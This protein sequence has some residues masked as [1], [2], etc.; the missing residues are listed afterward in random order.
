MGVMSGTLAAVDGVSS[1]QNWTITHTD[2]GAEYNGSANDGALGSIAGN[3]DWTGNTAAYG[4]V[5]AHL[6]GES[7]TFT[8]YT[9]ESSF[10]GTAVVSAISLTCDIEAGG[11][12]RYTMNFEADGAL[13]KGTTEVTDSSVPATF[14]AIGCK[15]TWDPAGGSSYTTAAGCTGY[16]LNLNA[17]TF[18]YNIDS[19]SGVTRRTV[20][21]ISGTVSVTLKQAD[22]A[23]IPAIGAIIPVRLYVNS[24]QYYE[25]T[26]CRVASVTPNA[27]REGESHITHTVNLTYTGWKFVTGT[28][29]KGAI[30]KPGGTNVWP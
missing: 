23:A 26:W 27:D 7:F 25:L 11:I 15:V 16:T 24:T 29:T 5:P 1:M 8:G 28:N 13:T 30:K 19:T 4:L 12:I 17:R 9:G 20:G 3:S 2:A 18:P 10:S 6:P 22:A 14:S 21:S